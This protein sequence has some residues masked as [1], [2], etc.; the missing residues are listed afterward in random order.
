MAVA[1]SSPG[2]DCRLGQLNTFL[3]RCKNTMCLL[4][5]FGSSGQKLILWRRNVIDL[6]AHVGECFP[7][8]EVLLLAITLF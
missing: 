3:D 8:L 1:F 4:F 2:L 5:G 7:V 6:R